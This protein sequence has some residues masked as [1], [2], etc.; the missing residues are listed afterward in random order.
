M[1]KDLSKRTAKNRPTGYIQQCSADEC[2]TGRRTEADDILRAWVNTKRR[3]KKTK[4]FKL[5]REGDPNPRGFI[6]AVGKNETYKFDAEGFPDGTFHRQV[7]GKKVRF[8][9][10][11]EEQRL[12]VDE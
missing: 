4:F 2:C 3:Q 11:V 10:V 7:R 8:M 9:A 6:V 5:M 1:K 12:R